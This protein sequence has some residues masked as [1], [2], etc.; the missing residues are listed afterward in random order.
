[1]LL[2]QCNCTFTAIA[3]TLSLVTDTISKDFNLLYMPQ[4]RL[5]CLLRGAFHK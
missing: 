1:M 3:G 2:M 5:K 4:L